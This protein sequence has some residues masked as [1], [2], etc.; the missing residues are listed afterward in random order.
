MENR[1]IINRSGR[2][3][4]INQFKGWDS[5]VFSHIFVYSKLNKKDKYGAIRIILNSKQVNPKKLLKYAMGPFQELNHCATR[6][7]P[8]S[9][10]QR[11]WVH[12]QWTSETTKYRILACQSLQMSIEIMITPVKSIL[13]IMYN[14]IAALSHHLT[15][16]R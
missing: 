4:A 6:L 15:N 11:A 12:K 7:S 8:V 14:N 2:D 16:S 13:K 3:R 9:N 10:H 1:Q 5:K